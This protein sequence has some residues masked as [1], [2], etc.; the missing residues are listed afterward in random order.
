MAT[1]ISM[2]TDDQVAHLARIDWREQSRRQARLMAYLDSIRQ[3][4]A[5]VSKP[6]E[7]QSDLFQNVDDVQN[8]S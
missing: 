6:S 3:P 1:E 8:S 4:S 7:V 5:V 2:L